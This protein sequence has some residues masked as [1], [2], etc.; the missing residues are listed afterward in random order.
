MLLIHIDKYSVVCIDVAADWLIESNGM[1][2]K[3]H[4]N[5]HQKLLNVF[6]FGSNVCQTRMQRITF[7]EFDIQLSYGWIEFWANLTDCGFGGRND[8]LF[9]IFNSIIFSVVFCLVIK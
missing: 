2:Q 4:K 7:G 6:F 3:T 8:F 1:K 9:Q 5:I